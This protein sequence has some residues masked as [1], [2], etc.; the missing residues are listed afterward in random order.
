VGQHGLGDESVR[1]LGDARGL[2][3]DGSPDGVEAPDLVPHDRL[4]P[5]GHVAERAAVAGIDQS[6]PQAGDPAQG[7]EVAAQRV[8]VEPP[9]EA[10]RRRDARQE[11]VTREQDPSR[12]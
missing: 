11:M 5:A 7:V 1:Q 12:G 2:V 9:L 3:A 10:H 4:D 6:R 8:G